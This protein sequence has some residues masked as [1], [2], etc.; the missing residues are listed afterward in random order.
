MVLAMFL[1]CRLGNGTIL[2]LTAPAFKWGL[3]HW[4]LSHGGTGE[5]KFVPFA[6]QK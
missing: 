4:K 2:A 3:K 1:G 6:A 5:T